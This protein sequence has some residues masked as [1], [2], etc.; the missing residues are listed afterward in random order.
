MDRKIVYLQT[1]EGRRKSKITKELN[2]KYY[3]LLF[4]LNIYYSL[5][6][7]NERH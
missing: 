6:G 3:K 4:T 1:Q 2:N 5:D 7:K